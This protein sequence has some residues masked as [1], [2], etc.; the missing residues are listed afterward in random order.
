MKNSQ[1]TLQDRRVR[2]EAALRADLVVLRFEEPDD[3]LRELRIIRHAHPQVTSECPGGER[4]RGRGESGRA[5]LHQVPQS[6]HQQPRLKLFSNRDLRI[7]IQM[8][9]FLL[10]GWHRDVDA[11]AD[12]GSV[13]FQPGEYNLKEP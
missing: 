11:I 5:N 4:Q 9:L 7:V 3:I 6:V 10:C 2:I 8:K 13:V 12:W 1:D